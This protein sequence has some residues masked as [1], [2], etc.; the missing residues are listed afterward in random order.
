MK[1][2]NNKDIKKVKAE[3]GDILI[4]AQG[5]YILIVYDKNSQLYGF[6]YLEHR[7]AVLL[8]WTDNI[9]DV[10]IGT[11][12]NEDDVIEIVKNKEVQLTLG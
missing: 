7:G 10:A 3:D 6:V 2:I 12:V 5:S 4:T 11:I 8:K 1:I 9:D